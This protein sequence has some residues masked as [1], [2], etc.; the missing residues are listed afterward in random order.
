MNIF[1]QY[2]TIYNKISHYHYKKIKKGK[3]KKKKDNPLAFVY[4]IYKV[5]GRGRKGSM[6]GKYLDSQ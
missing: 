1:L 4:S 6:N 2:N 5:K 3:K